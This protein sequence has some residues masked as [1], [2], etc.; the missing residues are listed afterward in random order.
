[1]SGVSSKEDAYQ[2]V[3]Y[4]S[5]GLGYLFAFWIPKAGTCRV[6]TGMCCS[7]LGF[8]QVKITLQK[9]AHLSQR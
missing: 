2:R 1:L 6:N 7:T 9:A 8:Y 3:G 4:L 5:V